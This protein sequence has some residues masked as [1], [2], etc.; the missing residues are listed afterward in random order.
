MWCERGCDRAEHR[1]QTWGR[2]CFRDL[3][4]IVLSASDEPNCDLL[5]TFAI[6]NSLPLPLQFPLS[7]MLSSP[8]SWQNPGHISSPNLCHF[9]QETVPLLS[10]HPTSPCP[11]LCEAC[12][13]YSLT[14]VISN[15]QLVGRGSWFRRKT[16][17][18]WCQKTRFGSPIL[19]FPGYRFLGMAWGECEKWEGTGKEA[20]GSKVLTMVSLISH[21]NTFRIHLGGN[22]GALNSFKQENS[23]I[24]CDLLRPCWHH[25]EEG[26]GWRDKQMEGRQAKCWLTAWT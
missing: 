12:P 13:L 24:H 8:S 23:I 16:Y 5:H 19:F 9:T 6:Y 10:Q 2:T 4:V 7:G 3:G 20:V 26:Y 18:L 22:R 17:W 14:W 11:V 15:W 1:M 25:R 21:A